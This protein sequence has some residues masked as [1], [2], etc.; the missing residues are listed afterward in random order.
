MYGRANELIIIH[1]TLP[2]SP[3]ASFPL[4]GRCWYVLNKRRLHVSAHSC[5]HGVIVVQSL[6]QGLHATIMF[7]DQLARHSGNNGR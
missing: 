6:W 5:C 7:K 4:L 2:Q 1:G 3:H